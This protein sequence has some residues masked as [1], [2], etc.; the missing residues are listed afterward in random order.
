MSLF[1]N[2]FK[3]IEFSIERIKNLMKSSKK[4]WK[5]TTMIQD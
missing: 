3:L 2:K 4:Y 5:K 1:P